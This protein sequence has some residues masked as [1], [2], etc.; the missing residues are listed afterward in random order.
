MSGAR[1]R[2]ERVNRAKR[3]MEAALEFMCPGQTGP[4]VAARL[5]RRYGSPGALIEAGKHQLMRQGLSE[6]N[7]LLL[8]MI[9]A[10][11]RHMEQQHFG[12]HPRLA[13]L[14]AAEKYLRVCYIGMNVE[15][16]FLLALDK[17]GKLIEC[18]HM[19]TG[20]EDSAPCYLKNILA[21]GHRHRPQSS[22]PDAHAFRGGRG[23]HHGADFRPEQYRRAV[24]GSCDYGGPACPESAGLR[25]CARGTVAAAGAGER[26]AAALAGGLGRG[27]L[28]AGNGKAGEKMTDGFLLG[29][30]RIN[31]DLWH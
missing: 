11:V 16:F 10:I 6:N 24:V 29:R 27:G 25:V 31:H 20:N 5:L 26:T 9:P 1:E 2:M 3:A 4:E 30:V 12:P 28:A 7:A 18:V 8:S 14:N 23:M 17:S 19:Q 21:E 22:Q 15:R 13:T